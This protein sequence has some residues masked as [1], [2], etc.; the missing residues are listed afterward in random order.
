MITRSQCGV[1][2]AHPEGL[3]A[4]AEQ[5]PLDPV[6]EGAGLAGLHPP[7]PPHLPRLLAPHLTSH[8]TIRD[9]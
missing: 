6:L 7:P 5:R 2:A 4:E 1:A 3:R 8:I 9:T